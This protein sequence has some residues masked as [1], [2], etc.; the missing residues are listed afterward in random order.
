LSNLDDNASATTE[1]IDALFTKLNADFKS[2]KLTQEQVDICYEGE[3]YRRI[4]E[5]DSMSMDQL[6]I[7]HLKEYANL[8]RALWRRAKVQGVNSI[9]NKFKTI[10]ADSKASASTIHD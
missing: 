8:H 4:R 6:Q 5:I 7:K 1:L 10:V 3:S 9:V 2:S